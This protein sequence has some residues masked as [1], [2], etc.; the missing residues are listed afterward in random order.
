MND[1]EYDREGVLRTVVDRVVDYLADGVTVHVVGLRG[2]GRSELLSLLADRLD[3]DG[4]P[5]VQLS[6]Q[7]AWRS[8]AYGALMAAGIGP[9]NAPGPRRGAGEMTAALVQHIRQRGVVLV[10]DADDLDAPSV[11]ALLT[12]HQQRGLQ[13]VTASRPQLPVR[14]DTLMTGL[15]PAVRL[16]MP[17]LDVD[18]VQSITREILGGPVDAPA[19]A[20]IAMKSGGLHGL[21]RAIAWVGRRNGLFRQRDG[22]WSIPDDIWADELGSVVEPYLAGATPDLWDAATTLAMLGPLPLDEADKAVQRIDLDRLFTAGLL[23]H[24]QEDDGVVGIYPPLLAEFLQREG[25][26]FGMA[27]ARA[28][29]GT[30]GPEPS[31]G[32]TVG[33]DATLRN[34]RMVRRAQAEVARLRE[35]WELDPSAT[36]AM[37]LVVAMRAGAV[38]APEIEHVIAMTPPEES[39]TG[40]RLASWYAT[41]KAVDQGD[42]AGGLAALDAA[43]EQLPG[44][45]DFLDVTRAHIVFL[46]DRVPGEELLAS[47]PDSPDAELVVILR[48]ELHLAAGRVDQARALLRGFD[49]TGRIASGQASVLSA[50][51]DV[52]AGGLDE[53]V[54]AA[55]R[56]FNDTRT[57]GDPGLVQAH[58]YAAV[59]GLTLGGRLTEATQLLS[60][61][62]SAT[63]LASYRDVFHTGV[64]VLGAVVAQAQGRPADARALA[65]QAAAALPSRGPFPAMDPSVPLLLTDPEADLWPL[66]ERRIEQGYLVG[67][68]F[69]AVEAAE[70]S[71]EPARGARIRELGAAMEGR[72]LPPVAEYAAAAAL[73]DADAIATAAERL[74]ACGAA[75]M[76]IRADIT[77]CMLLR[78]ADH[79][80]EATALA[81]EVWRRSAIAGL[82]RA[83]LFDRLRADVALSQRE[84]EILEMIAAGRTAGELAGVLHMS[85]RT[86][87]THLHN[88]SRKAGV[89][90]RD[91]LVTAATTWLQSPG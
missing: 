35:V 9:A 65:S 71:P 52:L 46:R 90:G 23:H 62:L 37:P 58:A 76:A 84:Q 45:R 11:G 40:A 16:R 48:A 91:M 14:P 87:E 56:A 51:A 72:M 47:L 60:S 64:L 15:N 30:T 74:S 70:R 8:E 24:S 27:Q 59:L 61:T 13:A 29:D 39:F 43:A 25:S 54:T 12:A 86:V 82:D 41:W 38:S 81:G 26:P 22:V 66:V 31:V 55:H 80:D 69:I 68:L 89:S 57:A 21:V 20:R 28:H 83:G 6:G 44:N 1:D 77:R 75:L 5:V 3:D 63:T 10:D 73:G 67:A 42:L 33:A 78:R 32:R 34:Q 4:R 7:S 53:G 19:L 36:T 79:A 85:V 88:I 2:S 18:Q 50:L 49:P 17:M